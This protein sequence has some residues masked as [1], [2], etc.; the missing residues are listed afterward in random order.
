MPP[1][2]TQTLKLLVRG[3]A[4]ATLTDTGQ[5]VDGTDDKPCR[6]FTEERP[7]SL[8]ELPFGPATIEVIGKDAVGV[9]KFRK[10]FDTFVGIGQ[11]NPTLQFD[12]PAPP[13]DA[14]SDI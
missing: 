2:V 8:A 12:L 7:Q 6:A 3:Q 5:K 4:V 10:T 14:G 1:V 13:V 9:E 11:V